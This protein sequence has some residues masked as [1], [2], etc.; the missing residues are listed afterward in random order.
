MIG[1]F[2]HSE[3]SKAKHVFVTIM[4]FLKHSVLALRYFKSITLEYFKYVHAC[5]CDY[6]VG[7]SSGMSWGD[8]C[9]PQGL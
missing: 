3:W 5:M 6:K 4:S 9:L 2:M 1:I 8:P 7:M